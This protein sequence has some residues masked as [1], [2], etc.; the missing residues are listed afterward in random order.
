MCSPRTTGCRGNLCR[1][2]RVGTCPSVPTIPLMS[3]ITSDLH[4]EGMSC[5]H[6]VNAVQGALEAVPHVT[7]KEV[8]IG[9]AR[10]EY[11][12]GQIGPDALREAIEDAGYEVRSTEQV[13]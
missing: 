9:R 13:A 7:V 8:G 6:C 3:T 12:P 10:V 1:A 2:R 4:I 5:Q 11:E